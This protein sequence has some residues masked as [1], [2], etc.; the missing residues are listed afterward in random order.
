MKRVENSMKNLECTLVGAFRVSCHSASKALPITNLCFEVAFLMHLS[1]QGQ[2]SQHIGGPF[3]VLWRGHRLKPTVCW[4]LLPCIS[5]QAE[6][7]S[8][9]Q[10]EG[11]HL[12]RV[13]MAL[14]NSKVV[15]AIQMGPVPETGSSKDLPYGSNLALLTGH[16]V[17]IC[18][19]PWQFCTAV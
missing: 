18:E 16:S 10:R 11:G 7:G 3:H 13:Q 5:Q 1:D 12:Q 9:A 17:G 14:S 19:G 6:K 2:W 4:V 15:G 8:R